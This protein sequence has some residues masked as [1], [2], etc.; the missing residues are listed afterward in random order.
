MTPYL[1]DSDLTIYC[2]KAEEVLRELPESDLQPCACGCGEMVR[3][4]DARGRP[5]KYRRG[6]SLR[7]DASAQA[8]A[9]RHTWTGRKHRPESLAKMRAAAQGPR[10]NLRGSRNGMSGRTGPLNPNYKDG[11]SPE[12]QRLYAS[13]E[14]NAVATRVY[15]RDGGRCV[16]CGAA[17]KGPRSLHVHHIRSW[18][19]YPELRFELSNLITL[20]R[21]CHI[22]AHRKGVKP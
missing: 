14:W 7:V 10:P 4:P 17:K 19:D 18:G 20:C 2:G 15:A 6:H 8:E 1:Q 9:A 5:R 11:S 3:N 21:E 13:G 22:A 16:Q 12:R